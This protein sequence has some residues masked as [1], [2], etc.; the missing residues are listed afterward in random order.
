MKSKLTTEVE[1]GALVRLSHNPIARSTDAEQNQEECNET[2]QICRVFG[3]LLAV[4][5]L[6]ACAPGE[7]E[8]G[9]H[10][11]WWR[12]LRSQAPE[13]GPVVPFWPHLK[14]RDLQPTTETVP[15]CNGATS[16]V[17][18]PL[19]HGWFGPFG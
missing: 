3:V 16:A 14:P 17:V 4:I 12:S 5:F 8:P 19:N 11:C 18:K 6:A 15:N 10:W 1:F 2:N 7:V 13:V 9:S